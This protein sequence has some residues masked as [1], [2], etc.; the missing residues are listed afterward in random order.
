M[1]KKSRFRPGF[2]KTACNGSWRIRKKLCKGFASGG[3]PLGLRATAVEQNRTDRR[4][5]VPRQKT[6]YGLCRKENGSHAS[7]RDVVTGQG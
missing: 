5:E 3:A 7:S 2:Q 4:I 6:S 1:N